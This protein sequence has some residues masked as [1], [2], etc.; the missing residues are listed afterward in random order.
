LFTK[1]V[2]M[3][4]R[5][6]F[7][8]QQRSVAMR[9]GYAMAVAAFVAATP[10]MAQVTIS[11][12]GDPYAA[13]QHQYQSDQDRAAARQNMNAAHQ[14]A[15]MGN[16]GAAAQDQQAAHQDWRAANHQEH[17]AQRDESGGVTVQL[18]R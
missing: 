7:S 2:W 1:T 17:D 18:G 4:K 6:G 14:E 13:Q 11:G 16:Y 5:S 15:A 9:I 12:G 8:N 3:E 10:A